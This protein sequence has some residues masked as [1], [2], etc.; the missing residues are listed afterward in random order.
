MVT[1]KPNEDRSKPDVQTIVYLMNKEEFER[2]KAANT[3]VN[4]R[5]IEDNWL[6]DYLPVAFLIALIIASP[7]GWKRMLAALALGLLVIHVFIFIGMWFS[8][9]YNF[10]INPAL[11]VLELKGISEKL[12]SFFYELLSKNPGT[13]VI[14][15]IITWVLVSFNFSDWKRVASSVS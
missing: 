10:N 2:K 5:F 1:F 15:A 7:I 6:N 8:F 3:P 14:M 11:Q 13:G 4:V 9:L 12:V